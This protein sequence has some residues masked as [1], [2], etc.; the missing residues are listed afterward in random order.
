MRMLADVKG[1]RD[2]FVV[3]V[4]VGLA[5]LTNMAVA[6]GVGIVLHYLLKWLGR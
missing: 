4:V 2:L 5:P 1:K 3:F 6:F